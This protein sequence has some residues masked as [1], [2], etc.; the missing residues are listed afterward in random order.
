MT[1][2]KRAGGSVKTGDE[3]TMATERRLLTP[4]EAQ[5]LA[6]LA[7]GHSYA[8]AAEALGVSRHTI[9]SHIRNI[10]RKLEVHS[11][12]AAIWRAMELRLIG[13]QG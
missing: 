7:Q 8:A 3:E 11:G 9:G 10:Y 13:G 12:R 5:L 6:L 1:H 2:T 4:R